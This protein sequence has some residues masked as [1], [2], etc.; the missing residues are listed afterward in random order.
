MNYDQQYEADK[1][2]WEATHPNQ[3]YDEH[4]NNLVDAAR[5]N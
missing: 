1:A 2:K 4:I 3:D 5:D